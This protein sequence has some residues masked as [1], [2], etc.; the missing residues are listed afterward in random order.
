MGEHTCESV[1]NIWY[2]SISGMR[3]PCGSQD[4]VTFIKQETK[5]SVISRTTVFNQWI[6][7][8]ISKEVN[9]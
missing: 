2:I 9:N 8:I 6:S 4:D 1:L 5:N 3:K 7:T